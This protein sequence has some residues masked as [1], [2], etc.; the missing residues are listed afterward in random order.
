MKINK[1]N[2]FTKTFIILKTNFIVDKTSRKEL[3]LKKDN[4][5]NSKKNSEFQKILQK[6]IDK[7][8]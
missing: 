4:H 5:N 1:Y 3:N 7:L 2:F 8:K 6:E